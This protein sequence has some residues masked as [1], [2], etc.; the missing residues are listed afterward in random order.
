MTT[1]GKVLYM[2]VM[3]VGI[4]LIGVATILGLNFLANLLT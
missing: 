1:K 2:A 3:M 4:S